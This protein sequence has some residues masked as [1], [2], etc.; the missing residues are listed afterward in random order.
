MR[1]PRP[2]DHEM[3]NY[4]LGDGPLDPATKADVCAV[5]LADLLKHTYWAKGA[6]A[7]DRVLSEFVTM[8]TALTENL[9]TEDNPN[10]RDRIQISLNII[11]SEKSATILPE[12]FTMTTS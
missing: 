8:F 9:A 5:M 4:V 3:L 12:G 2:F 6:G 11:R 10:P 1:L 7:V